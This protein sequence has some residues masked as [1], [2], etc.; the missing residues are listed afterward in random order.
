VSNEEQSFTWH[1]AYG[2]PGT[3]GPNGRST[4]TAPGGTKGVMAAY[5]LVKRQQAEQRNQAYQER[6]RVPADP[7]YRYDPLNVD[8]IRPADEALLADL[9][10]EASTPID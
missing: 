10:G 3:S 4:K 9:F 7:R 1:G 2:E 8:A 6:G 5:R